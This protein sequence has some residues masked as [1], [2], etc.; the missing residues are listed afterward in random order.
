MTSSPTTAEQVHAHAIQTLSKH[1]TMDRFD[2]LVDLDA[3]RGARLRTLRGRELLDCYTCFASLP[4]GWNHPD[5]ANPEFEAKIGRAGV[6]KPA[7]SDIFTPEVGA[8]V[9]AFY[10]VGITG[11]FPWMFLISGGALAVENA[12]KAAFDWKVRKNLEAGRGEKG[13]KIL[14]FKECF[15]GRTGYTMSLTDSPDPRKTMYYPKFDWPRVH[16][17]KL[18]FPLTDEV[19]SEVI[20]S[21]KRSVAEMEA[22]F[23]AHPHE[24]AGIIIEPIQG[25]GGDNHFRPEFFAQLRRIADEHEALLIFDEVQTGIGAT[26]T[27]WCHEQMGVE[28][29]IVVWGKKTQ[30]CGI[31]ASPRI[32]EV[33]RNV[34]VESSRINSTFG[35]NLVDLVRFTKVLEVIERDGLVAQTA[36]VGAY[37][38]GKL[39]DLAAEYPGALS[40]VR[41]RGT[42]LALDLA[43]GEA[44][45]AAHRSCMDNGLM[46][47]TSGPRS[48][49]FRPSLAFTRENVDEAMELLTK[50]IRATS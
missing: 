33:E 39:E 20:A 34:F 21:E 35:G 8:F 22:A 49:R 41:G 37:F 28:P 38:K 30:V 5:L 4:L 6:N 7:L 15:H 40:N 45:D 17:P 18:R 31:H 42:F 44:R 3:S 12:L 32:N 36:Q 48:L 11:D 9:E 23:A 47:L 19:L 26:G 25:E 46:L 43:D 1:M 27:F 14:H 29:D 2:L 10:R 13:G 24:I 50:G 16:N